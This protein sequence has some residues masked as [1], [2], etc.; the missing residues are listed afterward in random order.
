MNN[1]KI[2]IIIPTH[3]RKEEVLSCLESIKKIDY[4]NYEVVVVDDC[5]TDSSQEAIKKKFSEVKLIKNGNRLGA[6]ASRNKGIKNS[7][8][9]YLF[10]LD[11]DTEVEPDILTKLLNGFEKYPGAGM[12]T[13]MIYYYED[14]KRIWYAGGQINLLTSKAEFRCMNEIDRGQFSC[15]EVLKNGHAPTAFM[16]S[17]AAINKDGSFNTNLFMGFEEPFLAK[18]LERSGFQIIFN[19]KAKMYHKIRFPK[20]K[21]RLSEFLFDISVSFRNENIAF[22]T[23]KNRIIY[24]RTYASWKNFLLFLIFFLP[25]CLLIYTFKGLCSS[26]IRMILSIFLGTLTGLRKALMIKV[27]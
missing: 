27:N 10:F 21:N 17:R 18:K 23:S 2:S 25:S 11:S 26:R 19:P 3:N 14:K 12:V 9:E 5:S 7:T 13:P 16:V 24:M 20:Y 6:A 1:K 8:G 22:H 4:P 15:I